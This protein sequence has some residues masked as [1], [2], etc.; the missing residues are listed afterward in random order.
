M[1][2][3]MRAVG[4]SAATTARPA[5]P[6]VDGA[7]HRAPARAAEKANPA[8]TTHVALASWFDRN[9]DGKID[10]TTWVAGGDAFLP[11]DSDVAVTLDRRPPAE[12]PAHTTAPPTSKADV[13]VDTYRRYGG[14]TRT[15]ASA[16]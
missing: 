1:D 14:A 11:V 16:Q 15:S 2:L 8:P 12:P 13:A 4:T 3:S 7:A 5:P 9:G 6:P 10:D